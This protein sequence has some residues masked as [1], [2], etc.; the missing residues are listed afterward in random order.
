MPFIKIICPK[1]SAEAKLS[2]VDANF[3]GPRR[4]WKCH[5]PFKLTIQDNRVTACEPMAQVEFDQWMEDR[6]AQ[7]KAQSGGLTFSKREE[8][9]VRQPPPQQQ[10]MEF[11]RPNM[12]ETPEQSAPQ[13]GSLKPGE[14]FPPMRVSTFIPMEKP[15]DE[16][17]KPKKPKDPP[18]DRFNLFIPPQT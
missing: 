7:E 5:E 12:N 6:K 17:A 2:L 9:P 4:C 1:C 14:T 11:F 3:S 15:S 8:P 18:P 16:P 13:S 10:Q